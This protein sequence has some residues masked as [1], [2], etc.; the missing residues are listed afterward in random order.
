MMLP[1]VEMD[2]PVQ[3]DPATDAAPPEP[4]WLIIVRREQQD[5]YHNLVEAFREVPRVVVILDRRHGDRRRPD[6]PPPGVPERRR[7]D[8]R[9]APSAAEAEL[10]QTAGFRLIHEAADLSVYEAEDQPSR[11]SG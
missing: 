9:Q 4:R 7:R 8:R 6:V 10:W 2:T 11:T 1:E 5:L 3:P